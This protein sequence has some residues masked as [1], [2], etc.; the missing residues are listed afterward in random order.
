MKPYQ[1]FAEK[2]PRF[3]VER[4]KTIA[5]VQA[6]LSDLKSQGYYFRGQRE[7]SWKLVTAA[8]REWFGRSLHLRFSTIHDFIQKHIEFQRS[9]ANAKFVVE[10]PQLN[11]IAVL[12]TMQHFGG[13][14]PFLDFTTNTDAALFF[15]TDGMQ[16]DGSDEITKWFSIYAWKPGDGAGT[17]STND[18]F[19]WEKIIDQ[20][21][22]LDAATK[23]GTLRRL[24]TVFIKQDT[25]RFLEI[26]NER[27]QKQGGLFL[28]SS[29]ALDSSKPYEDLFE[30]K[31]AADVVD[32]YDGLFI[33]KMICLNIPKSITPEIKAYL[34]AKS[35][36]KDSLGLGTADW[37]KQVFDDFCASLGTAGGP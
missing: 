29:V 13:P 10:C 16:P 33:P 20:W 24:S 9:N 1:T 34:V 2:D 30:G 11:D 15:A 23:Y 19:N 8:Q 22:G 36:A 31:T 37:S 18:L 7:A 5:D 14:T 21:G 35:I 27:L 6:R 28:Y 26:I 4:L 3:V 12:S 17:G 32:I 25:G